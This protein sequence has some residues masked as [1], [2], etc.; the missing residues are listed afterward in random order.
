MKVLINGELPSK[1][2]VIKRITYDLTKKAPKQVKANWEVWVEIRAGPFSEVEVEIIEGACGDECVEVATLITTTEEVEER[3][4][5]GHVEVVVH[6]GEVISSIQEGD[7]LMAVPTTLWTYTGEKPWTFSGLYVFNPK[8][9]ASKQDLLLV[10]RV[11]QTGPYFDLMDTAYAVVNESFGLHYTI[12]LFSSSCDTVNS[13]VN[14]VAKTYLPTFREVTLRTA[15]PQ[16]FDTYT[17]NSYS[18]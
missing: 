1:S 9:F 17:D 10:E 11:V 5:N 8:K 16:K 6:P 18:L 2:Q 15:L 3:L 13:G 14:T 4:S 7:R 12:S